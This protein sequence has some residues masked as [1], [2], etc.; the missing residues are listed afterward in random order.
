MDRIFDQ[1]SVALTMPPLDWRDQALVI[2]VKLLAHTT[3][4]AIG[5]GVAVGMIVEMSVGQ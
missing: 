2:I 4:L 5:L 3:S 1:L